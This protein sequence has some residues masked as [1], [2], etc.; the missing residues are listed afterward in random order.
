M[1]TRPFRFLTWTLL[2]LFSFLFF[3][4]QGPAGENFESFAQRQDSL[5][6]DAY[7]KRNPV[8]YKSL[9]KEADTRYHKLPAA[10]Q[11][12][13]RPFMA[14]AYYNFCCLYSLEKQDKNALDCLEK[15]IA[16]GYMDYSHIQEDTDLDPIRNL[17]EFA[18]LVNPLR[19]IGDYLYILK[20][21]KAYNTGETQELPGFT[22]QPSSNEHLSALRKAFNL[23]SI[24]GQGHEISKV[25][26]LMH[27][28]HEMIPHDGNHGIPEERNAM[29]LIR[30]C[31]AEGRA[32]N[33]RGLA[34]VLNEV[35][36]SMGF[37][38][39]LL[40][41]L[42]KD[43]LGTDPD[44]HVINMV[45]LRSMK[46]WVWMDPTWDAYVMDENGV[47]LGPEEVRERLIAD[48][49]L[50]LSPGANW[51]HKSQATVDD[52][53]KS[54]MAKNLYMLE[55]ALSSEY[56]LESSPSGGK[57]I[58]YMQLIPLDYCKEKVGMKEEKSSRGNLLRVYYT[59][60][61]GKFW[62]APQGY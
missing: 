56:D 27:W 26:N 33:C 42:P 39:R 49:P 55:A 59:N 44:C 62:T 60:A 20:K 25:I 13:Y 47:L 29:S 8:L 34:T 15:S 17:P 5:M 12:Q 36:L 23:D 1:H 2:P 3:A 16:Y 10:Q 45:Y 28:L 6:V 35:Y 46:K 41:C 52:Y 14:G 43:S 51:N 32:L 9:M 58:S 30:T 38:S 11:K 22:Y 54:Y 37:P 48:Q 4:F 53:L 31:K 40:T 50:V 21:G 61:P 57:T 7:M 24:A 19:E 18:S